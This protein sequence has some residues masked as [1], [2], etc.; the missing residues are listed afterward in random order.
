MPAQTAKIVDSQ[1]R[2][3]RLK[4]KR[5]KEFEKGGAGRWVDGAFVFHRRY[6]CSALLRQSPDIGRIVSRRVDEFSGTDSHQSGFLRYP[7][8]CGVSSSPKFP[9]LARQGA[10][11]G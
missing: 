3:S 4:L 9:A 11:L 2:E 1:G 6:D 5:I 8:P 7:M 10:G